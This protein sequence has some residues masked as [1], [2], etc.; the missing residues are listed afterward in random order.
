MRSKKQLTEQQ[1]DEMTTVARDLIR[2]ESELLNSRVTWLL[3][4]NGLLFTALGFAW[5]RAP[6]ALVHLLAAVGI[7]V[8]ASIYRVLRLY[9]PAVEDIR[10]WWQQWLTEDQ[11]AA[12]RVMGLWSP[13]RTKPIERILRPWRFLPRAFGYAWV[14]VVIVRMAASE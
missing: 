2:V 7:L 13:S 14:V 1:A 10:T 11:Q 8:S 9:S 12:R 5:S 3:Q 4:I 6:D